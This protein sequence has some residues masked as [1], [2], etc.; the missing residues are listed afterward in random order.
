MF[1]HGGNRETGVHAQIRRQHGTIHH[2]KPS[3]SVHLVAVIDDTVLGIWS[4]D[5]TTQDVSCRTDV[6]KNLVDG[7]LGSAVNF[8]RQNPGGR[9]GLGYAGRYLFTTVFPA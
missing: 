8:L 9:L 7:V 4:D 3:V 6:E 2:I 1:G 5:T